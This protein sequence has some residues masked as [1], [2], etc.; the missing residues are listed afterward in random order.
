MSMYTPDLSACKNIPLWFAKTLEFADWPDRAT[1]A[2]PVASE[3]DARISWTKTC[4]HSAA[5]RARRRI[6]FRVA[7]A[8]EEC[9]HWSMAALRGLRSQQSAKT[10][11]N[12][13]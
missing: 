2:P 1:L 12:A 10:I 8:Y 13:L 9:H 6:E 5:A 7:S 3:S 11:D 4:M